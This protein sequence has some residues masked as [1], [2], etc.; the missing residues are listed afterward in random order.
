MTIISIICT[1]FFKKLC[2]LVW[3]GGNLHVSAKARRKQQISQELELLAVV[4][5]FYISG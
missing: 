5:C 1:L 2:A 3:G 4:S